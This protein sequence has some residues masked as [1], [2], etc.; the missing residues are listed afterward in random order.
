MSPFWN[1]LPFWDTQKSVTTFARYH[2][3]PQINIIHINMLDYYYV[4][5][6]AT[7]KMLYREEVSDNVPT[8]KNN[9]FLFFLLFDT[10]RG[11][12]MWKQLNKKCENTQRDDFDQRKAIKAFF[13]WSNYTTNWNLSTN[14]VCTWQNPIMYSDA[15]Q[16]TELIFNF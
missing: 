11:E 3:E 15:M 8:L 1:T 16:I 7:V 6:N 2:I 4:Y 12:K 10:K 14:I 5:T 9:F 13:G